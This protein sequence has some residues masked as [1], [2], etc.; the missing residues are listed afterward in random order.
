MGRTRTPT[1]VLDARGAFD[2]HPERRKERADEPVDERPLGD[3][4]KG[5]SVDEVEAW[6]ELVDMGRTWLRYPDLPHLRVAAKLSAYVEHHG[7][8]VATAQA[9]LLNA[10]L[11]GLGFRAVDRSKVVKNGAQEGGTRNKFQGIGQ[12]PA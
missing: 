10:Y 8:P 2:K 9:T 3:P 1:N 5:L 6:H 4:P 11:T 12:R 7:F